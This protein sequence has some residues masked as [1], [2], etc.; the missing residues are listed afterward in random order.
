MPPLAWPGERVRVELLAVGRSHDHGYDT[1]GT[2]TF[3]RELRGPHWS[4]S[5]L[6]STIRSRIAIYTISKYRAS[7]QSFTCRSCSWASR[8]RVAA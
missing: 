2:A 5:A 1:G 3:P 4:R 6:S 7:C 8:R